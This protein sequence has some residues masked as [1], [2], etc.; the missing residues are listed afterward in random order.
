MKKNF[1]LVSERH[2][3]ARVMEQVKRDVNRYLRRERGKKLGEEF[4]Y[5]AFNCR[6]GKSAEVAEPCHE[7]ELGK[8]LDA[9]LAEGWES[10]YLEIFA[11]PVKRG[12]SEG[13]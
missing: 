1:A 9:A 5:V 6:T 13:E 3:P 8:R 2:K 10:I 11:K 4:D 12:A 7:K